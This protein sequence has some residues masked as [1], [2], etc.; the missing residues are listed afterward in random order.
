MIPQ[1]NKPVNPEWGTFYRKMI[2]CSW[3][4]SEL[5]IWKH[6]AQLYWGPFKE[7]CGP[8]NCSISG[9]EAEAFRTPAP[10][11]EGCPRDISFLNF[12]IVPPQGPSGLPS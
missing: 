12:Q 7:P 3:V 8:Q 1:R 4:F 2:F 5:V 10:A 9:Q 6:Q 11:V